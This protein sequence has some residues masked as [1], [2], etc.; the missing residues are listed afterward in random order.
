VHT[1]GNG[2]ETIDSNLVMHASAV[3]LTTKAGIN[4]THDRLEI[5]DVRII[6]NFDNGLQTYGSE[7]DLDRVRLVSNSGWGMRLENST[8]G[9]V[10]NT[11]VAKNGE[12]GVYVAYNS[13]PVLI[14]ATVADNTGAEANCESGATFY[15]SIV[16][17]PNDPSGY[18][19]ACSFTSSDV[20]GGASGSGNINSNPHFDSGGPEPYALLGGSPCIDAGSDSVS[21][22]AMPSH[23]LVGN[24]RF[25]DIIP[26]GPVIDMGVH[27]RQ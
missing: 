16:W 15:N 6:F 23:D 19:G 22:F 26:G 18:S 7:L 10:S 17:D 27:E 3:G 5:H 1:C 2:I 21:G 25:Y 8:M 14:N 11:L 9:S 12:G 4:H 20:R 24:P 13:G